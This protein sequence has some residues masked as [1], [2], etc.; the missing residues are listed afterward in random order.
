MIVKT[1]KHPDITVKVLHLQGDN[2]AIDIECLSVMKSV[3]FAFNC[4]R[5]CIYNPK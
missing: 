4:C 5:Q 3:R 1:P 2:A